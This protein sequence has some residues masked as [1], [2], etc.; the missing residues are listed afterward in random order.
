MNTQP[1]QKL[2]WDTREAEVTTVKLAP[3]AK[4]YN[5]AVIARFRGKFALSISNNAHELGVTTEAVLR[6]LL[7]QS[8]WS[9]LK[10]G[11]SVG[12]AGT[13]FNCG[14]T[15]FEDTKAALNALDIILEKKYDI[16]FQKYH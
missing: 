4:N 14:K 5:I 16:T 8:G 12:A 7:T 13:G 11:A 3:K 1:K 10:G 15:G 9:D 2:F 6:N